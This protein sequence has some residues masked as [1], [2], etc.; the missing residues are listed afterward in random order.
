[1][2]GGAGGPGIGWAK[3][4]KLGPRKPREVGRDLGR[5]RGTLE[6]A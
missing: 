4:G 6:Y 2:N 1:M 5:H 3:A